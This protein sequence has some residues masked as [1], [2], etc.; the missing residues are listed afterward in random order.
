MIQE[1]QQHPNS[2]K[3]TIHRAG[4]FITNAQV[5]AQEFMALSKKSIGSYFQGGG[6]KGIG[7]GLTFEEQDALMPRVLDIPV[8]DRGFRQAVK[9]FFQEMST[10]V[11]AGKGI[12]LEIGLTLGNDKPVVIRD[13]TKKIIDI[14]LPINIMDFIRYRHAIHHP[15][16]ALSLDAAKGNVLTEFYV[17]DKE[18]ALTQN[19]SLAKAKDEALVL[20][21]QLKDDESKVDMMLTLLMQDPRTFKGKNAFSL[22]TQKLREFADN[23]ADTFVTTYR[24]DNFEY[25]YQVQAMINT[26]VL[27]KIGSQFIDAE[28]MDVIGHD[29]EEAIYFLRDETKSNQVGVLKARMQEALRGSDAKAKATPVRES[30]GTKPV[31]SLDI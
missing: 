20:Y 19:V 4:S 14:N 9:V 13:E 15:K 8:E 30:T 10:K 3:V 6:H 18:A 7:S 25:R 22:K 24:Q 31:N 29:L 16:V 23:K 5:N 2:K 12:E 27:K 26:G 21:L 28:T 17:F 11:P 1:Q